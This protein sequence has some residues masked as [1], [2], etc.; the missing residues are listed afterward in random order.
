MANA[1]Y[2]GNGIAISI[3]EGFS[4]EAQII[5]A[6]VADALLLVKGV[7]AAFALGKNDRHKTVISGRSLGE[8]N[9]QVILEKFGGGG[10]LTSAGAQVDDAPEEVVKQL[11]EYFESDSKLKIKED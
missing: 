8:I 6:Q 4:T 10:H 5:N 9:V 3:S 1:E 7:K 11:K 2:L